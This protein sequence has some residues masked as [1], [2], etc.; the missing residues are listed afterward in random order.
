MAK[1]QKLSVTLPDGQVISILSGMLN[2]LSDAKR[3]AE[4]MRKDLMVGQ[5]VIRYETD[6]KNGDAEFHVIRSIEKDGCVLSDVAGIVPF[7]QIFP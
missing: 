4:R 6:P 2:G 7:N 5:S 3:K 1:T